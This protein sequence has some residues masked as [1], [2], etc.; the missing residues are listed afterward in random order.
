[1][2]NP[3]QARTTWIFC[4]TPNP[5]I[6]LPKASISALPPNTKRKPKRPK[7]ASDRPVEEF[8]IQFIEGGL[9]DSELAR[10][11]GISQANFADYLECIESWEDCEKTIVVIAVGECGY[12]FKADTSPD[13]FEVDIYHVDSMRELAEQFVD[14]GLFGEIPENLT[15]YI[16]H[17]AIARDLAVDY[18]EAII[19]GERLVYRCG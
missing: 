15:H 8:E 9:I 12:R 4:Y 19:G 7:T 5:M 17:D 2:K 6:F 10:A 1:M 3:N 11:I 13:D 14:E 18:S 16:D